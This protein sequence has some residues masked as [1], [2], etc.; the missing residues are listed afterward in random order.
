VF[1]ALLGVSALLVPAPGGAAA[2]LTLAPEQLRP[3][4]RA[5]VRSVFRGDSIEEFPA[6]IVGVLSGGRVDGQTIIARATSERLRELGVPQGMSGSPVYVDG[7]LI[8]ALASS[9]PFARDPLFGITPIREML[10]LFDQPPSS[11]TGPAGGPAGVELT[12]LPGGVRF[13]EFRW[14]ESAPAEPAPAPAADEARRGSRAG[15]PVSL[16]IPLACGGLAPA[17][18]DAAQ[19]W[20]TPLGFRAV[21]GGSTPD[22]GPDAASLEPGSAVAVDLMRGDLQVSAIGTLTWRDGDRVLLF[23]HPFF[24]SG[25]VRL[26]LSTARIT[27]VVASEYVSFKLGSR[28]REVGV[29]T[30]DRRAGVSGTIGPRAPLL[31]LAVRIE[32]AR[33]ALQRFRFELVEDRMMAAQLAGLATLNSLLESGGTGPG[34]TLAWTLTLHRRQAPPLV[35]QDVTAGES[36]TGEAA[37]AINGPLAFL[38]G[39]PFERLRLDSIEV[40]I[41]VSTGRR[42]WA[43]RSVRLLDAAV[44]PGGRARIECRIERWRGPTETHLIEVP[45]AAEL[46]DGRYGLWVGGGAELSRLEALRFPARYRPTSLEDAWRRL[47]RLRPASALYA[48]ILASAPEVTAAGRDY[49][50]LPASAATVLSS[51]LAAGDLARRAEAALLDETRLP[52]GGVTRGELQLV[53]TVDSKAP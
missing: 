41:N 39:N 1:A 38:F 49:P 34:Q 46:P 16:P 10:R 43:L 23:G 24:Q 2:P 35:L 7:R 30:Q 8:G 11:A 48:V 15:A 20:F 6:E 42:L 19:Q 52:L 29:V 22:G 25:E 28:G 45:V 44:R 53:L 50:E 21:P 37:S 12:A 18:L 51:G 47:G 36:P 3:G 17:A 5:I 4:D 40:A 26:P 9:W 13:G 33:P 27:T 32:G 14:E 31:P